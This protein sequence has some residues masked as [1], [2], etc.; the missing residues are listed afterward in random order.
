MINSTGCMKQ[1]FERIIAWNKRNGLD[2]IE[3]NPL[4]QINSLFKAIRYI[5]ERV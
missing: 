5:Q 3:F 1:L 2:S 4:V